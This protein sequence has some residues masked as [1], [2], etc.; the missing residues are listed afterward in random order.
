MKRVP[1][2]AT[3]PSTGFSDGVMVLSPDTQSQAV[4]PSFSPGSKVTLT[5]ATSKGVLA[6][7]TV[8]QA[9]ENGAEVVFVT[10]PQPSNCFAGNSEGAYSVTGSVGTS[11]QAQTYAVHCGVGRSAQGVVGVTA[12]LKPG[13]LP[14]IHLIE[15]EAASEALISVAEGLTQ[16]RHALQ[17]YLEGPPTAILND[18]GFILEQEA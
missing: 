4:A 11:G 16:Q 10:H 5:G 17:S 12:I 13:T 18:L 7:G 15:S 1:P 3:E 9:K 14:H 2:D 6:Q 8:Y